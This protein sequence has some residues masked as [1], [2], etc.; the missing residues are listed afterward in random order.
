MKTF[1]NT[2]MEVQGSGTMDLG[3]TKGYA[4]GDLIK[5]A[6]HHYIVVSVRQDPP[7][8]GDDRPTQLVRVM[9]DPDWS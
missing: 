5:V 1:Y 4:R 3:L 7:R 9:S 2:V 8:R 6:G